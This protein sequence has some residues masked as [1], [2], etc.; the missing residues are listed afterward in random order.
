M[1]GSTGPGTTRPY[2]LSLEH[3]MAWVWTYTR[4]RLDL[5]AIVDGY[6]LQAVN[7]TF[8]NTSAGSQQALVQPG[9]AGFLHD[10]SLSSV[11]TAHPVT[12]EVEMNTAPVMF[13]PTT[14]LYYPFIRIVFSSGLTSLSSGSGTTTLDGKL[15][16]M[17]G[18]TLAAPIPG[19]NVLLSISP[20]MTW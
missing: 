9:T 3:A 5:D 18:G 8:S 14:E 15:I 11:D 12:L 20:S 17:G 19:G 2:G 13:D 7:A 4:W 16:P 10:I 1:S 6:K